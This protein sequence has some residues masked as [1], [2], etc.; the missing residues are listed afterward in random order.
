MLVQLAL[1]GMI[2]A[3]ALHRQLPDEYGG[4]YGGIGQYQRKDFIGVTWHVIRLVVQFTL[5]LVTVTPRQK[6]YP[7]MR[8][9]Y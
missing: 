5:T 3:Y 2:V 9:S 4:Y 1:P 8:S 6:M 7:S